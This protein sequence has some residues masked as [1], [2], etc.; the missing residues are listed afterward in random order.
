MRATRRILVIRT[1]RIGDV[2]LSLPVVT[3]LRQTFPEAHL[4]MLV[5]PYVREVVEDQPDL[6][7]VALDDEE[8]CGLG[9]TF[10]L[11]RK[12]RTGKFDAALLLHPT[13]RLAAAM[14]LARI[15][16]R[17]GTGYRFYAFLFNRRVCEH[18]KDS[19]RH[20]AEYNLSLAGVLGADVS[21][22]VFRLPV[23]SEAGRHVR[24]KLETLGIR[25]RDALVVLHP[26]SKGSALEWPRERFGL[27]A[28]RLVAETGTQVVVTGAEGEE[29]IV[30]EVAGEE[31]ER[32]HGMAGCFRLKELMA[33]LKMADLV[34]ANSTGP[35]HLAAAVGTEVIGLYPPVTAMRA[36]RWGP[37]GKKE[38]V[39]VPDVP[40]CV[41]CSGR[42]CPEWNCMAMIPVEE[43][44]RLARDKLKQKR[45]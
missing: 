24:Q 21:R 34:V 45:S 32:I 28:E 31:A 4:T 40:E 13:L 44:L 9:S 19:Q 39:L 18:R 20:E 16:L 2:V 25:D 30:A 8:G 27:L 42:R 22:V 43:V 10:R 3:A 41:R 35:L 38:C 7:A 1:D 6:D 37:Y 12:M 5:Q 17:I 29:E 14:A 26:G 11:V 23:S 15:P 33:L 36:K